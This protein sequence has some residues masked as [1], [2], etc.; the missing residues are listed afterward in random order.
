MTGVRVVNDTS[1]GDGGLIAPEPE[2]KNPPTKRRIDNDRTIAL[3]GIFNL[4]NVELQPCTD[5]NPPA[6]TN[7]M[8]VGPQLT[9]DN[10]Q[11]V[12][13]QNKSYL[14]C[15]FNKCKNL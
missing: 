13:S 1:R 11:R 14:S 5:S 3:P 12:V 6:I 4:L 15:V 2:L 9:C 10:G 7:P 8:T